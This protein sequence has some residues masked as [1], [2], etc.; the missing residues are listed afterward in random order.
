MLTRRHAALLTEVMASCS[1]QMPPESIDTAKT[2]AANTHATKKKIA[3]RLLCTIPTTNTCFAEK[4]CLQ[5]DKL[6]AAVD[7]TAYLLKETT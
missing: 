1:S 2:F 7:L 4:T 6:S 5:P 3:A